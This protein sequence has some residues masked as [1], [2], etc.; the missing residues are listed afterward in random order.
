M[1]QN[2]DGTLPSVLTVVEVV[3]MTVL[4]QEGVTPVIVG[5]KFGSPADNE[6]STDLS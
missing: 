6:V 4:V 1:G 2:V 3:K 5:N